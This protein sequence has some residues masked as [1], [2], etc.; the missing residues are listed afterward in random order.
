MADFD[1]HQYQIIFCGSSLDELIQGRHDRLQNFSGTGSGMP[2]DDGAQRILA[3]HE[4][5]GIVLAAEK[6]YG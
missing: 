6:G 2:T 3:E 4:A 5:L 1:H